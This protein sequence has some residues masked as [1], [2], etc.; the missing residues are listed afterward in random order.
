MDKDTREAF[1]GFLHL[2]TTGTTAGRRTPILRRPDEYGMEYED[3][4]FPSLDGTPLSG[5]FIPAEDAKAVIIHNHFLPGSRY[6]YAGHLPEFGGLGG[7]EVNFLPEY[8][9]L[10]DAG[11]AILAYD[12]RNHGMSGQGNGGIAGIGM[13]EWQ[14]V[15]GSLRYAKARPDTQ[16]MHKALLSVCLGA[17]STAIAWD[18]MPEEFSEVEAMIMLQPVSGTYIVDTF[19]EGLGL[20]EAGYTAFDAAVHERTGFRLA[21]QTPLPH[22]GAIGVP[23]L[24][25]QVHDDSMTK[26]QDVQDIYDALPTDDKKLVWIEGT[27]ER[28][29]GYNY[30]GE[31][32]AEAVDWFDSH[33]G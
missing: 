3:V 33:V 18:R 19:A 4:T 14:D 20:G 17:D 25:A 29:R 16:N 26:P 27:T 15:V 13:T 31:H 28:F 9:A 1:D 21:E 32:P 24:V 7:F 5:W 22:M 23:T 11:Y 10:H 30:F 8:K 6:G 12:M 2:W